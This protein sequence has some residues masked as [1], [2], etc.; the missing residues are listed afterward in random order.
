MMDEERLGASLRSI[1]V[2]FEPDRVFVQRLHDQ[3][4]TELGLV[5]DGDV[6]LTTGRRPF[7]GRSRIAKARRLAWLLAAAALALVLLGGLAAIGSSFL[8]QSPRPT[9][10]DEVRAAGTLEIAVRPDSP[11]VA[12]P[13]AFGGFDNDVAQELAQRLGLRASVLI[14]P[15]TDMLRGNATGGWDIAMPSNV[16]PPDSD[17]RFESTTPYYHWPIY[18]LAP[19]T[20]AVR[21]I[22]DLN[23][24]SICAVTGS[25]GEAWLS[26]T[27]NG[28][29][30]IEA[31]VPAPKNISVRSL[32]DDQGC[33]DDLASGRSAALVTESL[34]SADLATRPTVT[35]LTGRPV[36][37]EGR[38]IIANR[39][40]ADPDSLVGLVQGAL[41][42]M[43]N[44]GT[45]ANL[46]ARRFG[47]ENLT[48]VPI[49]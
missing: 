44:D 47:G 36:L 15:A 30:G 35:A 18:L 12:A 4:A 38:T 8:R 1:D 3:L 49:R 19:A 2:P 9:L 48:L 10:L 27:T 41:D 28:I 13:G 40:G 43:L 26:G 24:G 16:L 23:G 32:P 29:V 34:S 46:S 14:T 6:P 37:Y 11:Q 39:L 42:A 7:G 25:V 31:A 33:L 21:S 45:L 17:N 5:F 22:S 20:S